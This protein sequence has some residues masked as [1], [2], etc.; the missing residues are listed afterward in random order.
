[1]DTAVVETAVGKTTVEYRGTAPSLFC[2][3]K[4][5]VSWERP[6]H[7]IMHVINNIIIIH[8]NAHAQ[9]KNGREF[10]SCYV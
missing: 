6:L 9:T 3:L 1:M 8:I 7:I 10:G 4:G 2:R 5:L